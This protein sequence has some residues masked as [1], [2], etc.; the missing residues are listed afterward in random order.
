MLSAHQ[1][2]A[3][4]GWRRRRSSCASGSLC[5][6]SKHGSWRTAS[7]WPTF[8]AFAERESQMTSKGSKTRNG[9]SLTS[10]GSRESTL[11]ERTLCHGRAVV[12]RQVLR[13]LHGS[14][15]LL[16]ITGM[17]VEPLRGHGAFLPQSLASWL[18]APQ[19]ATR[20]TRHLDYSQLGGSG[21]RTCLYFLADTCRLQEARDR[22][23][24]MVVAGHRGH[25]KF[26]P[27]TA[28]AVET[29]LK[30]RVAVAPWGKSTATVPVAPPPYPNFVGRSRL[31][32]ERTV[33][34]W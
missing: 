21:Q 32:P 25:P 29:Q 1:P 24:P 3:K 28:H 27:N 9:H 11:F 8:F 5:G 2:F 31:H 26:R 16:S 33:G 19:P 13:T 18:D 17:S 4:T 12:A 14:H 7:H 34:G 22:P 30:S 15:H 20:T 10:R 6:K 23:R